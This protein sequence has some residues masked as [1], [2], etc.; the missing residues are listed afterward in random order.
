MLI[1]GGASA[2][3]LLIANP[4]PVVISVLKGLVANLKPSRFDKKFYLEQLKMLNAVFVFARKN[5][6]A[7]L[8]ADVDEPAKSAVFS[9]YPRF[10]A[11]HRALAFFCDT[12]RMAISAGVGPFELDQLMEVDLDVQHEEHSVPV[13]ALSTVADALP[14]LGIVAAVLGVCITMGA[15]G[16]PPEEIGHKVASALVGTFLGILL[17]YGVVGPLASSMAKN[18][19][20]EG[21]YLQFLRMATLAFIKGMAPQLSVEFARRSIPTSVRPSFQETEAMIRGGRSEAAPA[22]PAAAA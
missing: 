1:I 4:L 21:K 13:A 11:D 16:G 3:T 9:K 15:I 19:E 2:G 22:A 14:G 6:M 18:T 8:E 10:L 7:R 17:C 20:A 5:G 12:V